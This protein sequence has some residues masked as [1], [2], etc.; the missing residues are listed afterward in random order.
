MLIT[1]LLFCSSITYCQQD[2]FAYKKGRRT[3]TMYSKGSYMAFVLKNEQW[4]AGYISTIQNDSFYIV[5]TAVIY[6]P[7][8]IDT[9]RL[10]VMRLAIT[11]VYAMPKDGMQ[12]DYIN[13][14][15]QVNTGGGH[16]HFYWIK[17][18]WLFRTLGIGYVALNSANS[19]IKGHNTF[20]TGGLATAAGLFAFGMILKLE[21]KPWIPLG[22][23]YH[24]EYIKV[25][26]QRKG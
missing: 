21:Y 4:V 17:A 22:K 3:I 16:V 14:R 15:F 2:I 11:D 18:G 9:M 19:L 5:P 13:G 12:I 25:S 20:T 8:E 1:L 23:R 10:N 24:L 6:G 26:E 7:G